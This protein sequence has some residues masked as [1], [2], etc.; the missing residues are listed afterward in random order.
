MRI[1]LTELPDKLRSILNSID[2]TLG[3][4]AALIAAETIDPIATQLEAALPKWTEIT[5]DRNTHI[6]PNKFVMS[7]KDGTVEMYNLE[8]GHNI[9]SGL[10]L[11]G[12]SHWRPMCSID[13]P[14]EK[15][16]DK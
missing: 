7:F 2:Q 16:D 1:S 14:P 4:Y 12:A 5:E 3:K 15:R 10:V 11:A 8:D 13:F 6:L 9:D